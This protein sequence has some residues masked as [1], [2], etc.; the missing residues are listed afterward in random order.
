MTVFGLEL[1]GVVGWSLAMTGLMLTLA[2]LMATWRLLKGPT[3]A[4]RV[5]ALDLITMILVGF[6]VVFAMAS[7]VG[8]YMDAAIVLS[9][10]AFLGTVAFA[11]FVE[12]T[13][14]G[15]D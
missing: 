9:L 6:L 10:V 12:R 4:D 2:L 13:T 11:R 1:T 3:T 8:S 7:G 14:K 15:E 5:V